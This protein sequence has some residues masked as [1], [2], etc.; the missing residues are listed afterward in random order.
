MLRPGSRHRAAARSLAKSD[1]QKTAPADRY[2]VPRSAA[3]CK[4]HQRIR[5]IVVDGVCV[6]VGQRFCHCD[7]RRS[8]GTNRLVRLVVTNVQRFNFKRRHD[9]FANS[10]RY[11]QASRFRACRFRRVLVSAYR[12]RDCGFRLQKRHISKS[13]V[14]NVGSGFNIEETVLCCAAGTRSSYLLSGA[15]PGA[16]PSRPTNKIASPM[17]GRIPQ[18]PQQNPA[19]AASFETPPLETK[20]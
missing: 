6:G 3:L 16:P 4:D 11:A 13:G 5:D 10:D 7:G 1:W 15:P 17:I 14:G 18:A 2:P 12:F 9:E 8:G 19:H 20:K